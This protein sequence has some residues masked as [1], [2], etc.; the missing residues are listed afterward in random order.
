[1]AGLRKRQRVQLII[2]GMALLFSAAILV[3]FALDEQGVVQWW[4]SPSEVAERPPPPDQFVRIGG[5]V[6][7]GSVVRGEGETVTFRV[8]DT[9]TT[10]EVTF[11]G[12][13]P[14]LFIEGQDVVAMGY[15]Q[16]G[17]LEATEI[18]A[19][20]DET[21]KPKEAVDALKAQGVFREE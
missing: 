19:R 6:E 5:L 13:L 7:E 3:A 4:M 16:N 9:A 1:M 8:T 2:V 17:V 14:D 12:V 20:H 10:V 15:L 21:Y 18:L 11:T